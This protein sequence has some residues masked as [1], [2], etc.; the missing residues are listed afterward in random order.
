ME[1]FSKPI[2]WLGMEKQN[3][4]QQKNAFINQNTCTTTQKTT[5]RFS[6]LRQHAAWKP[7]WTILISALHKFVTYLLT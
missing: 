2:S 5:V 4:T 6:G 7:R 1:M 3:L